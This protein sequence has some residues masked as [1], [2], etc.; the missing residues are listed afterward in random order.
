MTHTG[1]GLDR[2]LSIYDNYNL[3]GG[4]S[5]ELSNNFL[6]GFWES[7]NLKSLQTSKNPPH[8]L[9]GF[10]KELVQELSENNI[11]ASQF[12]SFQETISIGLLSNLIPTKQKIL[13]NTF[14]SS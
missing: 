4:F 8:N 10:P 9:G 6:D 1:K 14:S 12:E 5:A 13:R 7:Y 3:M 11:D 2:L